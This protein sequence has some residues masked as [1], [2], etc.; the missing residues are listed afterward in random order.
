MGQ[1]PIPYPY[2]NAANWSGNNGDPSYSKDLYISYANKPREENNIKS[3]EAMVRLQSYIDYIKG[4]EKAAI[5]SLGLKY[6][7]KQKQYNI[8]E[9]TKFDKT[10]N[11]KDI[12][13]EQQNLINLY[14]NANVIY[15]K[16]IQKSLSSQ[17]HLSNYSYAD[18]YK[19]FSK[20]LLN[21]SPPSASEALDAILGPLRQECQRITASQNSSLENSAH[22]L[23]DSIFLGYSKILSYFLDLYKQE[24]YQN[25]FTKEQ[26]KDLDTL[27]QIL[28]SKKLLRKTDNTISVDNYDSKFTVEG[29][30]G[31]V[32][33]TTNP[34]IL[35]NS[36]DRSL[37]QL[38]RKDIPKAIEKLFGSLGQNVGSSKFSGGELK[39]LLK[40]DYNFDMEKPKD[41]DEAAEFKMMSD[42]KTRLENSLKRGRTVKTDII[43]NEYGASIKVGQKEQIKVDTRSSYYSFVNFIG[44]YVEGSSIAASLLEP[45]NMHIIIN[46]ILK[47][48]YFSSDALNA[49]LA[50]MAYAFFGATNPNFLVDGAKNLYFKKDLDT[51]LNENILIINEQGTITLISAYLE[52]IY[53]ALVESYE[54]NQKQNIM[55]VYFN[56]PTGNNEKITAR[57]SHPHPD[58]ARYAEVG[59]ILQSI[60][61]TT[62]IKTFQPVIT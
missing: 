57:T 31:A 19:L 58:Y 13:T 26:Q 23:K 48:G 9:A 44:Q 24:E 1:F 18:F 59:S 16:D 12:Q 60:E 30:A 37:Q 29:Q 21:G 40:L 25:I 61:A 55:H 4:R 46:N 47:N 7:Q 27:K 6:N 32:T 3:A 5:E 10:V 41:P 28:S 34:Q 62:Y 22:K 45:T 43:L 35:L 17:K 11:L 51:N 39:Y 20:A 50:T 54:N 2:A 36:I 38:N 14:N 33:V 52:N 15:K 42:I 53:N 49:A 56:G 8:F